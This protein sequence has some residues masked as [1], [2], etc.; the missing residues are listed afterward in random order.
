ME[1]FQNTH[2]NINKKFMEMKIK[3]IK[4]NQYQNQQDL[5]LRY[6]LI[7]EDKTMEFLYR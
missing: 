5:K 4:L 6:K 3:A 2:K 1:D 7:K